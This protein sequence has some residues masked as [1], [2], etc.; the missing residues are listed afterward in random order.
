MKQKNSTKHSMTQIG[1]YCFTR[2]VSDK[3]AVFYTMWEGN[4]DRQTGN[5]CGYWTKNG[6]AV[7]HFETI[8]GTEL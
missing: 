5:S 4:Y 7:C 6:K 2:V 1:N 3:G 8:D